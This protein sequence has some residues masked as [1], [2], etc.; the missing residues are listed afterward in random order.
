MDDKRYSRRDFMT[1]AGV[2]GLVFASGLPGCA[3]M[4]TAGSGQPDFSFVQLS[5]VHWGYGNA[6]VNPD[7]RATVT[8]AIAA[9]NA[10]E[11]KPDFVVFTGDLT[12]T[13][14][15]P[16]LRRQRLRE[17][18]DMAAALNVPQVRF[19][20][21]EHDASLDR[22]QAYLEVFGGALYYTFDHK[23]VHFI[24]LDNTSDPA[25]IL[26]AAQLAW[27]KADLAKF[28][29]EAPIVVLT[30]RPLFSLLPQW[31]WATRDGQAAVDLLMPY[32]NVTVFYGHIH[33][34]HHQMTGHIAHHAAMAVMFP[35]SPAGTAPQKTQLPWDAAQPFKGLGWRSVNASS[36]G[37]T[38]VLREMP[39]AK[40]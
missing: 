33:H 1:M 22:G 37:R 3:N 28:A 16:K 40:G 31:D 8:R 2:G 26:G 24:V 32:R 34:Q 6:K 27:L 36:G 7:G 4:G 23:G 15:D 25:P 21:G 30:H 29:P 5:D 12:Q 10:M 19:F 17:V 38:P 14:D 11:Q 20:A 18:K 39:L 35:L 9:V 13:T